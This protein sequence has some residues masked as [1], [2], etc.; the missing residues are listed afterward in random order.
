MNKNGGGCLEMGSLRYKDIVELCTRCSVDF[1]RDKLIC[2]NCD[3]GR[4]RYCC[5]TKKVV[6]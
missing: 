2:K 6:F 3:S 4:Y 1:D 5:L